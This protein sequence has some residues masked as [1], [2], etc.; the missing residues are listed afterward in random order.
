MYSMSTTIF[1]RTHGVCK[2]IG[3]KTARKKSESISSICLKCRSIWTVFFL[4]LI[5]DISLNVEECITQHPL[6]T[7]SPPGLVFFFW[8]CFVVVAAGIVIVGTTNASVCFIYRKASVLLDHLTK[9][10]HN[11]F[12]YRTEFHDTVKI[13]HY[14]IYK[15]WRQNKCEM[16]LTWRTRLRAEKNQLHQS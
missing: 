5:Y 15:E 14:S 10:K 6:H 4:N 9:P 13:T 1:A 7:S 3:T 11:G 8:M 16:S 12:I 2:R